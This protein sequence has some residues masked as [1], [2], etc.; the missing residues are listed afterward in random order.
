MILPGALVLLL[1]AAPAPGSALAARF[2]GNAAFELS[3]SETTLFPRRDR[4][5]RSPGPPAAKNV[6]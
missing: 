1:A 6:G 3:D 5:L 2:L 4:S